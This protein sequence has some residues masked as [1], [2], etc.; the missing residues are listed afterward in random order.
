MNHTQNYQLNQ[1]EPGDPVLRTDFNADN[2]KIDEVLHRV[3]QR[4]LHLIREYTLT[5]DA[6]SRYYINMDGI[7]W[8]E[9]KIIIIDVY[10]ATG[11]SL[12]LYFTFYDHKEGEKPISLWH[13][14]MILFPLGSE[15]NPMFCFTGTTGPFF[16]FSPSYRIGDVA[17]C[18]EA[19]TH[20]SSEKIAA[21]T[22]IVIRGEK[23]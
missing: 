8:S 9:W 1:W 18:L 2:A 13:N 6:T 17:P 15:A 22:R 5:A 10:P 4:G 20:P 14:T 16:Y 12:K 11:T 7:D 23:I 19:A 21:G 3:D